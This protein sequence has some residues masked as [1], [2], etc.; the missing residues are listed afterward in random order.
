MRIWSH[1]WA[2]ACPI[3]IF[4]SRLIIS[5][6]KV[7]IPRSFGF[8]TGITS[9]Q[10]KVVSMRRRVPRVHPHHSPSS[11]RSP[12]EK[13]R[14]GPFAVMLR[15]LVREREDRK[16]CHPPGAL[17][18]TRSFAFA[19]CRTDYFYATIILR[20]LDNA[21][22]SMILMFSPRFGVRWSL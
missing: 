12:T 17:S 16:A 3:T 14:K 22:S 6:R 21:A 4:S 9:P 7:Q 20:G 15:A 18:C 19:S 10:S 13:V 11:R 8:G 5:P 1:A 2:A